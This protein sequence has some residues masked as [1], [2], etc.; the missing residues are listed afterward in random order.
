LVVLFESLQKIIGE[1]KQQLALEGKD[2]LQGTSRLAVEAYM[3]QK[4]AELAK[5]QA[6][7]K[8]AK[9]KREGKT[10]LGEV[11]KKLAAKKPLTVAE[12]KAKKLAEEAPKPFYEG[13]DDDDSYLT[14][15]MSDD[16]WAAQIAQN[17]ITK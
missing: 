8:P 14:T 15:E 1:L 12:E 13:E 2:A 11:A 16:E 10:E 9:P 6:P 5:L 7:A 3:I 4:E 17:S